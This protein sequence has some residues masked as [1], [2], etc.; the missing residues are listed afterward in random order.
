MKAIISVSTPI[1]HSP[2]LSLL[3]VGTRACVRPSD[4]VH[5][6]PSHG[7][8]LIPPTLQILLSISLSFGTFQDPGIL[9]QAT[10]AS[11]LACLFG[12]RLLSLYN[13][14]VVH[15]ST[16]TL[17]FFCFARF[18]VSHHSVRCFVDHRLL[19]ISPPTV[20]LRPSIITHPHPSP[21]T[22]PGHTR[23]PSLAF[24][25]TLLSTYMCSFTPPYFTFYFSLWRSLLPGSFFPQE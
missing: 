24:I 9:K 8:S 11:I 12:S 23:S 15:F 10:S 21:T 5:S 25:P 13:P 17:F 18:V 16:P 4:H 6:S 20:T 14:L 19:P 3:L 1:P 7:W 2:F 22:A